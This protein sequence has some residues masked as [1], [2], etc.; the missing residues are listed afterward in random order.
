MNTISKINWFLKLFGW[1]K[2]PLIAYCNPKVIEYSQEKVVVKIKLR[3]KT[4]NHL[5]SMYFGA[6]AIGADVAGG[7]SAELLAQTMNE[8]LSLAFKSVKGEFIKRPEQD[9]YFTCPDVQSVKQ[10]IITAKSTGERV[11]EPVEII[12]TCPNQFGDEPVAKFQ[13]ELSIKVLG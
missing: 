8:K 13:L 7:I 11:N 3:R 9:V 4:K 1:L 2:V 10:M 12:A 6:L 5:G